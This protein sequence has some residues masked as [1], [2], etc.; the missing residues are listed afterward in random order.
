MAKREKRLK[1]GI[2]SIK[3]QIARH[4]E[5]MKKGGSKDTTVDYWKKE[6]ESFQKRKVEQEKKLGKK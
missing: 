6:V 4:E 1:K 2:E 3:K 5:K